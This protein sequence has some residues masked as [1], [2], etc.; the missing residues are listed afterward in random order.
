M[1]VSDEHTKSLWMDVDVASGARPL[2][3]DVEA[4]IVVVGSGIAGLS[5]AYELAILGRSVVVLDRG[6]IGSGMTAR[7]TAHLTPICDDLISELIKL[8]GEE[9]ARLFQESQAAAV[10][11]IEAIVQDLDI[12]CNFRRLDG[13][14]FP[15][16]GTERSKAK[17]QLDAEYDAGR[18]VGAQVERAN[19]LP[20][21]DLGDLR[22]LRYPS[23]ATFHPL[24]YL[25]GLAAAIVEHGGKLFAN[26][27]VTGVEENAHGVKVTTASGKTVQARQAVVATNSPIND[28]VIIHSKQAPY[29]SYAMAFTLPRGALPDALYWDMADPY[30]YVR[31]SQGPGATDYLIAGGGDHKSGTATDGAQRFEAI[32]AWIRNL[33]PDLGKEVTRWS[34]Q[35]MDPIDYTG[36]IGRNP[37]DENIYIVTGDSGQGMTHGALA[38]LLLK[39]VIVEGSSPWQEVYDP[40]R[41]TAKALL[42]FVSENVT[43]IKNFAVSLMPVDEKS[44]DE[45]KPGEGAVLSRGGE[46]IAAY[47]DGNG[48]L[49]ERSAR[50]THLGCEISW[51]P[52]EACW[53]CPCHGSQFS[54][55]G[56][57]LNGPAV[58]PLAFVESKAQGKSKAKADA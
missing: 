22:C 41:K 55:L 58:A 37:S 10:D 57:V 3:Q 26:S 44:V 7:T 50:C 1:N 11:R 33:V 17:E 4:D 36:F 30:H 51:N 42:T 49:H 45:I 52:T 34:G 18:K 27:A 12:S 5:V 39:A 15:A 38:G 20:F 25:R 28:R 16:L 47:R 54:P 14:L 13:Y 2:T 48:T 19:G 43:A 53:D 24:K 40:G 29:R 56:E 31:L 21:H 6:R 23:Q 46:K 32:E 35:L 8:R 9:T